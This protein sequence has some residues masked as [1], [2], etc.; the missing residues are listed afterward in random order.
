MDKI[1]CV[2][3]PLVSRDRNY[4]FNESMSAAY[5]LSVDGNNIIVSLFKG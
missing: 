3:P 1:P 4:Q 5:F 2:K